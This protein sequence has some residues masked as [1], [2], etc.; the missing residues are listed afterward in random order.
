MKRFII[1]K[2]KKIL[3]STTGF[4]VV[5]LIWIYYSRQMNPLILPSPLQTFNAFIDIY[6]SGNLF[7]NLFITIRRTIIGYGA[8]LIIGFMIA[9]ILNKSNTL[10]TITRPIITVIQ[11]TPPVIWLALAVIW[12]GIADNL[13]PIFLIFIVTLPIIFVNIFEGL[14]DID[15]NL[16]EMA[17]VYKADRQEI[18]F[19]IYVPSLIP[20]I[21]SAL[22]IGMAFAWKS[23][24]F[25]E[26]LGSNSGVGFALSMANSNLNT[27][28]LFAWGIILILLMLAVEYL[29]IKPVQKKATRWK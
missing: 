27:D 13:T 8:A 24:I 21:F 7:N 5:L 6:Q 10:Y 9:L 19:D 16:I 3:L 11:T 28:K 29:I 4:L 15:Q 14:Q 20:Y 23:T 12:F 1:N 2:F 22:S 25:A 18:F 17:E 26:F